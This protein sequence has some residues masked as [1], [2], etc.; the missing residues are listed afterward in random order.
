MNGV[1]FTEMEKKYA[2]RSSGGRKKY[3]QKYLG[4]RSEEMEGDLGW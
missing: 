1:L 4:L 2:W 3:V